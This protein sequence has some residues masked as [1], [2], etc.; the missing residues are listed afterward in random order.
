MGDIILCHRYCNYL[1]LTSPQI[2]VCKLTID[3]EANLHLNLFQSRFFLVFYVYCFFLADSSQCFR[4]IPCKTVLIFC[5]SFGMILCSNV[6]RGLSKIKKKERVFTQVLYSTA[7]SLG[8]AGQGWQPLMSLLHHITT[9]IV[10]CYH[11]HLLFKLAKNSFDIFS[12]LY[13]TN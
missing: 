5:V 13:V 7:I 8:R 1:R 2:F 12:I 11:F 9:S 6:G 10:R 4:C 3:M